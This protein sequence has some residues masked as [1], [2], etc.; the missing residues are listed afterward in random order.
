MNHKIV[1]TLI[2][3]FLLSGCATKLPPKINIPNDAR[4]GVMILIDD[5]PKLVHVGTT[6][7]NNLEKEN[8]SNWGVN[9]KIYK[10]ISNR[11][12]KYPVTEITPSKT[13]INN[14]LEFI[15]AGWDNLY[16]NKDLVEDISK[17]TNKHNIDFL[18]TLEPH[19]A[20]VEADSTIIAHGYGLYTRCAFGMCRA[21]VLNHV[22]ARVYAMNPPRLLSWGVNPNYE[23]PLNI[24][25]TDDISKLP[26][27]EIDKAESKFTNYIFE[28]VDSALKRANLTRQ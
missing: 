23:L 2:F 20:P 6:V 27:S 17:T 14:R 8:V 26:K 5:K 21:Q 22:G 15:S 11:L 12:N 24:T 1:T 19:S 28:T 13:L 16:L 25:F 3:I 4:I 18:I 9:N 7:F 10:H